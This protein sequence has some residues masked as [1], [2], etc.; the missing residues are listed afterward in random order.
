MLVL[1][2]L[3]A[4][5][6]ARRAAVGTFDKD[7][8]QALLASVA[9]GACSLAFFDTFAFPQSAG[10]LFLLIGLVGAS[11]RLALQ[12]GPAAVVARA[13]GTEP[14]RGTEVAER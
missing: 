8:A 7:L 3:G 4:A 6:S 5:R 10:C 9:A 14:V 12:D 2:T 1:V 13:T 11:R